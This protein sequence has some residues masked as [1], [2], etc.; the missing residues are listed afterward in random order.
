MFQFQVYNKVIQLH[1]YMCVYSF[2]NSFPNQIFIEYE[3]IS[4]CYDSYIFMTAGSFTTWS[5]A[6]TAHQRQATDLPQKLK[7]RDTVFYEGDV[8]NG[9]LQGH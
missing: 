9:Q 6:P 5:K 4:L 3:A 7:D 8:K 2:S 1:M